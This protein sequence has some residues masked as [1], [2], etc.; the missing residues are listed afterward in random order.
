MEEAARVLIVV[1]LAVAGITVEGGRE[2]RMPLCIGDLSPCLPAITNPVVKLLPG[3]DC[4]VAVKN[5]LRREKECLC[6]LFNTSSSPSSFFSFFGPTF[7]IDSMSRALAIPSVCGIS[8]ADISKCDDG[9]WTYFPDIDAISNFRIFCII[10]SKA[11]ESRVCL[12]DNILNTIF[13]TLFIPT[14]RFTQQEFG[15][16]AE[17]C[18]E[19]MAGTINFVPVCLCP[20]LLAINGRSSSYTL[21]LI[22]TQEFEVNDRSANLMDQTMSA[23]CPSE[24]KEHTSIPD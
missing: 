1:L 24:Q 16:E 8:L 4:C 15:R 10:V 12:L 14:L 2:K 22:K 23:R 17:K 11:H 18:S 13:R 7:P 6:S 19:A 9:E 3:S 5:A 20:E 21:G